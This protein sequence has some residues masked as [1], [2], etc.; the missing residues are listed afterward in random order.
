MA[1][2]R[3]FRP[4]QPVDLVPT[5]RPTLRYPTGM[6]R[7]DG[8]WRA[9][10]TPA[11]PATIRLRAVGADIEARAWGAGSDWALEHAPAMAG[12]LDDHEAL[13][14][15]HPL[16]E[17]LHRRMPGVRI[18]RTLAVFEALVPAILE[19]KVQGSEARR[20]YKQVVWRWGE[21]APGPAA[22]FGLRVPP[23]PEV[24]ARVPAWSLHRYNVEQKRA[25][26]L[27]VAARYAAQ[28]EACV[29]LI[30]LEAAARLQTLPGIGP[31][32]AAE[33]AVVALG[34]T[35]AVSIGDFHLPN[36]VS[37]ALAGDVRADDARMLELLEPWRGQRARV[38][39]LIEASGIRA[40]RF[41]PR[42]ALQDIR[43]W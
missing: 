38:V 34:D 42:L 35:D 32:T 37:Y 19:Q 3:R 15:G 30:P 27:N 5:L 7:D 1:A 39:K 8:I 41:G 36:T 22:D 11:G 9:T 4:A 10:R 23:A 29:E 6:R 20:S 21:R 13:L 40:P 2:D 26:T 24:L 17:D 28:L 18:P 31:W 12:A 14:T 16:V 33:V 25:V 43:A